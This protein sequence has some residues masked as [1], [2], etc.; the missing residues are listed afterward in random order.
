MTDEQFEQIRPWCSPQFE[1]PREFFPQLVIKWY[2][3]DEIEWHAELNE[4]PEL[5]LSPNVYIDLK[6]RLRKL[7]PNFHF[8]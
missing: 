3:R 6:D 7:Y 4:T 8:S 5:R 2:T 1:G